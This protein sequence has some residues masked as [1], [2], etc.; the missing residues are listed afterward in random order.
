MFEQM[1]P[2]TMK[3]SRF[4]PCP[5]RL[6]WSYVSRCWWGF[7]SLKKLQLDLVAAQ[8]DVARWC[9]GGSCD[10]FPPMLKA[11]HVSRRRGM[12][13]WHAGSRTCL[14]CYR[15]LAW[16]CNLVSWLQE[17]LTR[18][19]TTYLPLQAEM[20]SELLKA[21]FLHRARLTTGI[22]QAKIDYKVRNGGGERVIRTSSATLQQNCLDHPGP[23]LSQESLRELNRIS[24]E[25][26]ASRS[27]SQSW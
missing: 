10:T 3:C 8:E 23:M 6:M 20:P 1:G 15:S 7:S 14:F 4:P 17:A 12:S 19:L 21:L 5:T 2:K 27:R 13:V 11:W 18:C 25:V 22:R 24:D 26:H 9:H 16:F